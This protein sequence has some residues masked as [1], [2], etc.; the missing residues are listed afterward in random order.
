MGTILAAK[1]V[2]PEDVRIV[3]DWRAFLGLGA[4]AP[5]PRPAPVMG[6]A[7]AKHEAQQ[8]PDSLETT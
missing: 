4:D 2:R 1:R 6:K 8:N 5:F 7:H 3:A